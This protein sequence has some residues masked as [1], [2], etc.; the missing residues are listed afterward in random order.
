MRGRTVDE[1]WKNDPSVKT[2][3]LDHVGIELAISGVFDAGRRSATYA[4]LY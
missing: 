2:V 3:A 4:K 1:E